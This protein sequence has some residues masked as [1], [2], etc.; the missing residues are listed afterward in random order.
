MAEKKEK[1]FLLSSL[2]NFW[3]YYKWPFLGGIVIF[4]VVMIAM[5]NF[6]SVEEPSDASVLAVFARPLTTQEFEFQSRLESVIED[7]D[8]NGTK[9]ISTNALYITE[10][11]KSDED[12]LAISKFE[13][14]IAYAQSD[15]VLLDGT[16]LNRFQSK[17]FL[18]PLENY[19]DVSQFDSDSLVYRDDKAVAVKLTN[20]KLLLDMQFFIDDVY[21][22][23][24]FV[25]EEGTPS[26]ETHR[27]N[28]A[29]MLLKLSEKE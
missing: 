11:G 15:L 21:A 16:N 26:L 4:F 13:N 12:S 22:G 2:E 20:S 24:M 25:P 29:A 8:G 14:T 3:Y 7:A 23:I 10:S 17:D 19:V 9:Q 27:K 5:I 18:E 28:A 1:G 6:S